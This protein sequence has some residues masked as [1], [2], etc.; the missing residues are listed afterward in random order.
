MVELYTVYVPLATTFEGNSS[1]SFINNVAD[2]AGGAV[3]IYK[4]SNV[5]IKDNSTIKFNNNNAINNVGG[6]ILLNKNCII[7]FEGN[8]TVSLSGNKAQSNGGACFIKDY[9]SI[10]FTGHSN[11][12][13]YI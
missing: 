11:I 7:S 13:S 6:A 10:T 4:Y 9:S 5:T 12:A 1:T 3:V 2:E 8:S